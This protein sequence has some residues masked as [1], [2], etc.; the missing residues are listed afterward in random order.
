LD[1]NN[2]NFTILD[3][4][5]FANVVNC[6]NGYSR[7]GISV[8]KNNSETFIIIIKDKKC[9]IITKKPEDVSNVNE[10]NA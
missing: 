5:G 7:W 9:Y 2:C 10:N 8:K 6:T 4:K 1:N 3:L